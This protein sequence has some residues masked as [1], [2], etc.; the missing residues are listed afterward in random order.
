MAELRKAWAEGAVRQL[1]GPQQWVSWLGCNDTNFPPSLRETWL[2]SKGKQKFQNLSWSSKFWWPQC[3]NFPQRSLLVF[4]DSFE[5]VRVP[6]R[7]CEIGQVWWCEPLVQ[8]GSSFLISQG[9][10]MKLLSVCGEG[11]RWTSCLAFQRERTGA[12]SLFF[13]CLRR[14]LRTPASLKPTALLFLPH[15]LQFQM[16]GEGGAEKEMDF[17]ALHLP[18]GFPHPQQSWW[19]P[20]L[21]RRCQCSAQSHMCVL[22]SEKARW[23]GVRRYL[24]EEWC[25]SFGNG[26][27]H[28]EQHQRRLPRSVFQS[29]CLTSHYLSG[30]YCLLL[31]PAHSHCKFT[32]LYGRC[33]NKC[34]IWWVKG[35]EAFSSFPENHLGLDGFGVHW[36][37]LT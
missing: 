11:M 8:P 27:V 28:A 16:Q 14:T 29:T 31:C 18:F 21:G 12:P 2:V 7:N 20:L 23:S 26:E 15:E 5:G 1:S 32:F 3:Q 35:F 19:D 24:D 33:S 13:L 37:C 17:W 9:T 22:A 34:L 10:F 36:Y 25:F 4:Y 6:S 30:Y